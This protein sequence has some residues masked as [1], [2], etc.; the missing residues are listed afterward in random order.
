[1]S[2]IQNCKPMKI[3]WIKLIS[4]QIAL[5][6][7]DVKIQ[8]KKNM[9]KQTYRVSHS[10]VNKVILPR[11]GYRF[12]LLLTFWAL[13]VH[14]FFL[15]WCCAPS[16]RLRWDW[17]NEFECTFCKG[18]FKWFFQHFFGGVV[19]FYCMKMLVKFEIIENSRR[20]NR[21]LHHFNKN[22]RTRHRMA[23][24]HDQIGLLCPH[25]SR[26]TLFILLW[27]KVFFT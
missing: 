22:W 6:K 9:E 24:S 14:E 26:I 20:N 8:K 27:D 5:S 17:K 21:C 12:G 7:F 23:L 16:I 4:N 11:W 1:M 2:W 13:R 19:T 25:Q 18:I 15:I 10:K 3:I